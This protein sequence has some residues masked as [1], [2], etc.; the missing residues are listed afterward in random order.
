MRV[1][2]FFAA[3][4]SIAASN[5]TIRAE[6]KETSVPSTFRSDSN[7]VLVNVSVLDRAN[8]PVLGLNKD[9]FKLFEDKIEQKVDHFA[10][11]D[12]PVSVCIVFDLSGS[13]DKRLGVARDAIARFATLANPQ[14]EFCLVRFAERT[15][16]AHDFT[17]NVEDIEAELMSSY[18]HGWT[19]LIDAVYFSIQHMKKA[20]NPRKALLVISDGED[21]KSRYSDGELVSLI[22]ESDVI[23]YSLNLADGVYSF[24]PS[25]DQLFGRALM[26]K[27]ASESGGRHFWGFDADELPQI[28]AQ[29]GLE[30]R[31]QYI[32]GYTPGNQIKD[33]KYRKIRV[34]FSEPKVLPGSSL[35]HRSGYYAP[36]E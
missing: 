16:L 18:A 1:A 10:M 25:L 5:F 33:G 4:L 12:A 35:T 22:R 14:D 30:L 34:K 17:N 31:N 20:H 23:I 36:A 29:V 28:A 32:L 9:Q 8:R 2:L 13:M 21:N 26:G 15:E 19:A 27:M 11:D 3:F 6:V 7:L 24:K